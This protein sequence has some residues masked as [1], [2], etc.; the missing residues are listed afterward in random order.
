MTSKSPAEGTDARQF[1]LGGVIAV[2]R[3]RAGLIALCM[4]I[5]TGAALGVS[6]TQ[7]KQYSAS[8]SLLFR[9]PGFAESLFG[10]SVTTPATDPAREAA[11]NEKL[12]GLEIVAKR[13]AENLTG[14]TPE[15][16]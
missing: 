3:R 7:E 14:L 15:E 16:V 1:D 5:A 8:A 13:T 12:V 10:N 6:L 11:T 9:N 2:L 4:V